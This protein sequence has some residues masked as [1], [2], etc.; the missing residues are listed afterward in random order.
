ME[1]SG[2][3]SGFRAGVRYL[4]RVL[5]HRIDGSLPP[6]THSRIRPEAA[7]DALRI[8]EQAAEEIEVVGCG[9]DP[10]ETLAGAPFTFTRESN[11]R[12]LLEQA[13]RGRIDLDKLVTDRFAADE[14]GNVLAKF[15][16]GDRTMI[17]AVFNWGA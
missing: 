1:T 5:P 11:Y 9:Y 16:A 7:Q 3:W 8:P 6:R 2:A 4:P 10:E 15:A 12:Y 17:G 14:I 13:G